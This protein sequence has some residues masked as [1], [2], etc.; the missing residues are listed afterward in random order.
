MSQSEKSY[1]KWIVII[2][3]YIQKIILKVQTTVKKFKFKTLHAQ[4]PST[5]LMLPHSLKA[6]VNP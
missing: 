1:I 4:C 5:E 6:L 2:I 3:I